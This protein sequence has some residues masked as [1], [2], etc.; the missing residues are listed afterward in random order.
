MQENIKQL[1]RSRS[2]AKG[3]ITKIQSKIKELLLDVENI[4]S[5]KDTIPELDTAFEAFEAAH[6]TYHAN[7]SDECDIEESQQYFDAEMTRV[8]NLKERID[9]L[10][11]AKETV[12]NH[13]ADDALSTVS[14]S[15]S[16]SSRSS[17][18]SSAAAR[19]A[20]LEAQAA[21]LKKRQALQEEELR[22]KQRIEKLELE[23]EI[24][25]IAAEENAYIDLEKEQ[26]F[27]PQE[28]HDDKNDQQCIKTECIKTEC[29]T[30][31][32]T[33][34]V[35]IEYHGSLINILQAQQR[36]T[37]QIE[38]IY[39]DSTTTKYASADPATT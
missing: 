22:L 6:E 10:T 23:T 1:K 32:Q 13:K 3:S 18:R 5:I 17:S 20:A 26:T 2:A 30:E 35:K 25:K 31:D 39:A 16:H 11:T 29:D 14:S 19:K 8:C 38:D 24:A 7:L 36:H 15:K 28:P 9:L 37:K 12:D 21:M 27:P 33:A 4:N 34:D